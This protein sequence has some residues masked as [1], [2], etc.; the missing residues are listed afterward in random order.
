MKERLLQRL[1]I[2]WF[3]CAS[4]FTCFSASGDC[5]AAPKKAARA[6]PF[7][8]L[9]CST[10]HP[11]C[12][13]GPIDVGK[14][15]VN[16]HLSSLNE[17][18]RMLF[19]ILPLPLPDAA[20]V[21]QLRILLSRTEPT[22]AIP[23]VR[24]SR[25]LW[26]RSSATLILHLEANACIRTHEAAR[27]LAHAA[28]LRAAPH[29]P[30]A[31]V[32]AES[33]HLAGLVAP[34]MADD[35]AWVLGASSE[36]SLFERAWLDERFDTP[37]VRAQSVFFSW[38]DRSY[39]R[40]PASLVAGIWARSPRRI[41]S[42]EPA[43]APD[44]VDVLEATFRNQ[45]SV[46]SWHEELYGRFAEYLVATFSRV[47]RPAWDVPWPERARGFVGPQSLSPTGSTF[48]RVS[49]RPT[50]ALSVQITWEEHMRMR[51]VA[52]RTNGNAEIIGRTELSH[53]D[54]STNVQGTIRATADTA[55]VWLIG[56][57]TGDWQVPY[58][59]S[60]NISEPHGYLMRIDGAEAS[61]P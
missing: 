29:T 41:D 3:C 13:E 33:E 59:P 27:M 49:A 9:A 23:Y 58:H 43:S 1:R 48:V 28:L 35:A 18:W 44:V 30:N 15:L 6:V 57:S 26:E 53:P 34:C 54:R 40:A 42:T 47:I 32:T 36:R 25:S 20:D 16:D 61:S 8:P 51:W 17:A 39:G 11:V 46:I 56:T 45:D 12:I 31:S 14:D 5:T 50:S 19:E 7:R 22:R 37:E 21:S 24:D 55:A 60:E 52:L 38:L 10:E 2:P 4:L